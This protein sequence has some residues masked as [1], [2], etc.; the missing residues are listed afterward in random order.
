MSSEEKSSL[1]KGNLHEGAADAGD[2]AFILTRKHKSFVVRNSLLDDYTKEGA[3]NKSLFKGLYNLSILFSCGIIVLFPIKRWILKGSPFDYD[4]FNSF[5][6]E[7]ALCLLQW[8]LF[9]M[10]S[11]TSFVLQYLILHG[12]PQ[13]IVTVLQHSFQTSLFLYTM[14]QALSR[15][16][17]ST[18]VIFTSFA[19][20]THFMKMHSYTNMN[21]YYRQ[22][23]LRCQSNK[24]K[25]PISNY[26]HNISLAN[27]TRYMWSPVLVY[28]YQYPRSG[29]IRILFII[30]KGL[31]CLMLVMSSYI[32][33][34]ECIYPQ[35]A[36]GDKISI[37]ALLNSLLIPFII[38]TIMLFFC[39]FELILQVFAEITQFGDRLFYED[40]W[41]STT[42]EEFNRKWNRP[43]HMF[44]FRHVYLECIYLF[45]TSKIIAQIVTF[46]FS[47]CLHVRA[48]LRRARPRPPSCHSPLQ[49]A[50]RAKASR[51]PHPV[52]L[53]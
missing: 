51:A 28:E 43:V 2:L 8:P 1:K 10:W 42:F 19:C 36:Q 24:E 27:F 37:F 18:H 16:W 9:Y 39:T 40:Y 53:F 32:L 23:W 14:Y 22:D 46:V 31:E 41:N 6:K 5:K 17:C 44:L 38:L 52:F 29:P 35:I 34:S 30:R 49:T 48:A 21:R 26:P 33:V 11:Y 47:A 7:Y 50:T 13:V 12:V 3:L 25:A 20:C 15:D 4:F 45:K